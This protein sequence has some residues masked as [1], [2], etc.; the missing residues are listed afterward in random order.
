MMQIN[1]NIHLQLMQ[2][3]LKNSVEG[4]DRVGQMGTIQESA[5]KTTLL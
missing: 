5:F 3:L 4:L 2:E 1:C